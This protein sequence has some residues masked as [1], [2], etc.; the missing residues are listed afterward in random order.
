M[1]D[2]SNSP[3][4]EQV[5]LAMADLQSDGARQAV[6]NHFREIAKRSSLRQAKTVCL[7]MIDDAITGLK[8]INGNV[9]N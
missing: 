4:W 1:T 8:E 5:N 7:L 3:E 9:H 6:R 2:Y